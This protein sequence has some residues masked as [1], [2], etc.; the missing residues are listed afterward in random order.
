MDERRMAVANALGQRGSKCAI[1][2]PW[3][4]PMMAWSTACDDYFRVADP[5]AITRAKR[6]TVAILQVRVSATTLV[7]SQLC[8]VSTVGTI[9]LQNGANAYVRIKITSVATEIARRNE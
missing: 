6:P 8:T 4:P 7:S 3:K 9:C 1:A 5:G 2:A